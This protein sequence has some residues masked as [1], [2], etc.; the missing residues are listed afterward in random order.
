[1]ITDVGSTKQSIVK[2]AKR[3][4]K[5]PAS[6]VG[7]HPIAGTEKTG[8]SAAKE[9]LFEGH[10]VILTPQKETK[11]LKQNPS[12]LAIARRARFDHDSQKA[13]S[14]TRASEPSPAYGGLFACECRRRS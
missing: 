4:V 5:G 9:D 13:R 2:L 7:G 10:T 14:N 8:A 11:S 3:R 6:F 12:P 1:M